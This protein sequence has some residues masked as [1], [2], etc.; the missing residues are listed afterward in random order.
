MAPERFSS[1]EIT[2][3]SDIYALTCVLYQSLTGELPFP[4]TT[5]EQ[6]AM[7]HMTAPPPKPSAQRHGIP[8]AMDAVVATGLAKNPDQRYP[9]AKELAQAAVAALFSPTSPNMAHAPLPTTQAA[10]TVGPPKQL[11]A[12]PVS[13]RRPPFSPTKGAWA[14]VAAAGDDH[15]GQ[16]GQIIEICDAEEDDFDVIIEFRG[17]RHTY[18]FRRDELR[19]AAT[20]V[21]RQPAPPAGNKFWMDVG[22]DPIRIITSLGGDFITLR[23]YVEDAPIFL[24]SNGFIRVCRSERALRRYL[25]GHHFNDMSSLSTYRDVEIAASKGSLPLGEIT[26]ENI[27]VLRGLAGDIAAGPD[28]VDREQLELA[29]ELLRDVGNYAKDTI[30]EHYLRAG[31]PLGD[32]VKRVLRRNSIVIKPRRPRGDP[33]TQWALVEHFLESRLREK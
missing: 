16:V 30:V 8:P 24:G 6:I 10:T 3:S 12:K 23:C 22:I 2:P 13:R 1:A 25:A 21:E 7:A 17:D 20:P 29:V 19:A 31:Q 26:P 28:Q 5:L 15:H 14:K 11:P 27:Y 9:T 18:A 4:G 33:L 32:L